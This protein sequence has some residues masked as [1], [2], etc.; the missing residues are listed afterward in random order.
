MDVLKKFL[1]LK[2][3]S[4]KDSCLVIGLGNSK[5][6]PDSLGPLVVDNIL[7]TSHLYKLGDVDKD[8]R[9]VSCFKPSVT[10][11]TGIETVDV[12]NSIVKTIKP[13]FLIVID[14]LST[15]SID[16]LNK[17]IQITNSGITPG[18]GVNNSRISIS[19]EIL[20]IPVIVIGIPTII[21][22][23]VIV[24]NTIK[25]MMKKFSYDKD[26]IDNKKDKL[27]YKID[28]KEYEKELSTKEKEYLL[29]IVGNLN[30]Q[31][32]MKL[33]VE[34]LNPIEYNYMVTPKEIDFLIEKM[35]LLLGK[36]LNSS[37]NEKYI[38]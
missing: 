14:A 37:L 25:Y 38:I 3:I 33:V 8:Y 9:N 12:I 1:S 17:T 23:S 13:S 15:S 28:Y 11:L 22:S 6:T 16:R 31:E 4:F 32:L 26:N 2:K 36:G 29:G 27:K 5:S 24:A 30:E 34:V 19:K 35:S 10:G 20:N 18:S 21:D 7:V